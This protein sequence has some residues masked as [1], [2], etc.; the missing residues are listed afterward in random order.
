MDCFPDPDS[1]NHSWNIHS[2]CAPQP[3][4][5]DDYDDDHDDDY[6]DEY[7]DVRFLTKSYFLGLRI[8]FNYSSVEGAFE[9]ESI[10]MK[11]NKDLDITLFSGLL[12]S[13]V[14][15]IPCYLFG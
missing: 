4:D 9:F 2:T 12:L 7:D 8:E 15:S 3:Y 1:N 13:F 11:L 5:D 14:A 10:Y 6:E